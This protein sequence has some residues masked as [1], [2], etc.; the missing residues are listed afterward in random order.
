[1]AQYGSMYLAGQEKA[2]NENRN[3]EYKG[4]RFGYLLFI[5]FFDGLSGLLLG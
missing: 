3:G 5:V 2:R 4:R 1:M